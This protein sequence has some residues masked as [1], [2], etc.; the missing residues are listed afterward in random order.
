MNE[1]DSYCG[2]RFTSIKPFSKQMGTA[3]V[4]KALQKARGGFMEGSSAIRLRL[5]TVTS[6]VGGR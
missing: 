1:G 5:A 4:I 6:D 2:R 3:S